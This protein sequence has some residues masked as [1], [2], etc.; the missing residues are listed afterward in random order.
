MTSLTFVASCPTVERGYS[1]AVAMAWASLMPRTFPYVL[2]HF[3]GVPVL[4]HWAPSIK[5]GGNWPPQGGH[6]PTRDYP[7]GFPLPIPHSLGTH[8]VSFVLLAGSPRVLP[9]AHLGEQCGISCQDTKEKTWRQQTKHMG[10][11]GVTG[12]V[13][14]WLAGQ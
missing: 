8:T 13:Q 6:Q 12:K 10:L 7:H 4:M 1:T 3:Q 11:L 14:W 2:W 5:D 9:H